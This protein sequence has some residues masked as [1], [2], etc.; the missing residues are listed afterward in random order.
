[1]LDRLRDI[2]ERIGVT[3]PD[4]TAVQLALL[5]DR[6]FTSEGRL[7]KNNVVRILQNSADA[8]L[9]SSIS[10]KGASLAAGHARGRK[11]AGVL[12]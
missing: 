2:V 9:K 12:G 7:S 1:M 11:S 5:I 8:L 3:C 10:K 6:A 4:D